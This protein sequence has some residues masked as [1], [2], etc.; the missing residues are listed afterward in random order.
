MSKRILVVDDDERV[1]H[2]LQQGLL[3]LGDDYRIATANSPEA[4]LKD[5]AEEPTDLV[6]SDLRMPNMDGLQL[7]TKVKAI[8]E[9]TRLVLMTAYGTDEVKE[10]ANKLGIFRFITKPFRHEN[11]L[12]VARSALSQDEEI[13]ISSDGILIVPDKSL[14]AINKVLNEL[15]GEVR[16]EVALMAD[17]SGHVVTHVGTSMGTD[18]NS[19]VALVA[20]SFASA[21][22]LDRIF[23]HAHA[24]DALELPD[25][26]PIYI[27]Y[28]EGRYHDCY[29]A[30]VGKDLFFTVVF[31]R[32]GTN[33]VGMVWL[34]MRRTFK[35]LQEIIIT[36]DNSLPADLIGAQETVTAQ[37]DEIFKTQ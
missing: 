3:A 32:Q 37:F 18:L 25:N 29:S 6:I 7:L 22:E 16:P 28:Q 4:A 10:A 31:K 19:L 8:N 24:E 20:G 33:K 14:T 26:E 30:N 1:L 21:R 13:A 36:Q 34:Y 11:L 35:R 17:M 23:A 27:T 15:R 9:K 5:I 12:N 2:Y